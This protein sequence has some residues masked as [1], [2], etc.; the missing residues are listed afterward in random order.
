MSVEATQGENSVNNIANALTNLDFVDRDKSSRNEV[1]K[2]GDGIKQ[3]S[4]G[5]GGLIPG[6][7]PI[8][9]MI[10]TVLGVLGGLSG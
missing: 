2:L 10:G 8:V 6:A 7:G 4:S 5:L 3:L 9:A 1:E